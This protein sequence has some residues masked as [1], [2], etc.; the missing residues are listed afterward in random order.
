MKR[1]TPEASTASEPNN[2]RTILNKCSF[3]LKVTKDQEISD[4]CDLND[5]EHFHTLSGIKKTVLCK[6]IVEKFD[7]RQTINYSHTS[8]GL[9]H[10]F[11]HST[12]GFYVTNGQFKGAM[13]ECGFDKHNDSLN[14]SFCVTERSIERAKKGKVFF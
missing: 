8:Y 12:N 10:I 6:W 9:K 3:D 4:H 11:E 2:K 7:H 13:L 5:P 14:W 1:R